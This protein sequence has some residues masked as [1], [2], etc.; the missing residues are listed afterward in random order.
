MPSSPLVTRVVTQQGS[1]S[2]PQTTVVPRKPD[3]VQLERVVGA[4]RAVR[5]PAVHDQSAVP[6]Q[7]RLS[8]SSVAARVPSLS[9]AQ[10]LEVGIAARVAPSLVAR[11]GLY[12]TL[13]LPARVRLSLPVVLCVPVVSSAV[14]EGGGREP[15]SRRRTPVA[16]PAPQTRL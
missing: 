4:R 11:R 3:A 6:S 8:L 1:S 10:G 15:T 2:V 7:P 5:V 9:Q 16:V 14:R 12:G 13:Q